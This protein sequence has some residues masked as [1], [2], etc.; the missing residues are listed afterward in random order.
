MQLRGG[1][2]SGAASGGG[3]DPTR[4]DGPPALVQWAVRLVVETTRLD[5][6]I[7][8]LGVLEVALA[9]D[10]VCIG[11]AKQRAMLAALALEPGEV[12]SSDRLVDALWS[13]TPPE[14]AQ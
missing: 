7:R 10:A 2:A 12:V 5:L 3:Y 4:R 11:S 6:E 14:A 1:A 13:D 9:G 8:M